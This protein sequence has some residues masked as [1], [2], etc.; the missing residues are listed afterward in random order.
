MAADVMALIDLARQEVQ[1]RFG[2]TLELEI[3]L[4]GDW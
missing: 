3:E 1:T 4:I 2:V